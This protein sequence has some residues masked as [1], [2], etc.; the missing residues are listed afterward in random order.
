MER[1]SATVFFCAVVSSTELAV[2][3]DAEA[4]RLL[5]TR[6]FVAD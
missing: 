3:L 4:V 6:V 5:V 2:R 1:K